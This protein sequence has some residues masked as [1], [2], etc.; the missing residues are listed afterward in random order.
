MKHPGS[1]QCTILSK[2]KLHKKELQFCSAFLVVRN[3]YT[4][5]LEKRDGNKPHLGL[6]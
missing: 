2:E 1:A 5:L 3:V 6:F 4:G